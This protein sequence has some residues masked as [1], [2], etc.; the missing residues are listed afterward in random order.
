MIVSKFEQYEVEL[1]SDDQCIDCKNKYGCPLIEALASGVV[2]MD[3]EDSLH[4]EDCIHYVE[5][6]E[7]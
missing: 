6:S 3:E 7:A 2:K 5:G 1:E 4:I